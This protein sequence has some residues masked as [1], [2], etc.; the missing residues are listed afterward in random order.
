MFILENQKSNPANIVKSAN[1]EYILAN[2]YDQTIRTINSNV[3]KQTL[4]NVL[5]VTAKFAD[6]YL[7]KDGLPTTKSPLFQGYSTMIS[8]FQNRDNRMRY[9]L[10]PARRTYWSNTKYRIDWTGDAAD[11][12]NA[13]YPNFIPSFGSGYQNQKWGSERQVPDNQEGYDY[14]VIRYAEVLLN[15][16]EATFELNGSISDADLDKSLNLVRLRVNVDNAMPKLSNA[17]VATNGLDMRT[18]IRRERGVELYLEGFRIDD[19]KRWKTAETEM[20]MPLVGVHWTGTEF[21]TTWPGASATA[22]DGSG[23]IIIQSTRTWGQKNYLYPF[24]TQQLQLNPNLVQ[25]TGWQ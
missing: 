19:L 13:F 8:E 21:Q 12:A 14:P 24:P 4:A 11:V 6:L 16:A 17:F 25:N 3:T 15:Y 20:P 23:R 9:T 18:E 22:K 10:M 2:R 1:N 5:W 7:C